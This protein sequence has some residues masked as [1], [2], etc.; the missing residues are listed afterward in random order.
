[1]QHPLLVPRLRPYQIQ[2]VKWMVDKEYGGDGVRQIEGGVA[3]G[4]QQGIVHNYERL[5]VLVYYIDTSLEVLITKM[6]YRVSQKK[7]YSSIFG[8]I[9]KQY[10][11]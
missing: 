10:D 5:F 4:Q 2:A 11:I 6:Y 1:M 7:V 9:Q 3:A 8:S